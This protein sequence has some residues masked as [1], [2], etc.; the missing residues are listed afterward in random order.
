MNVMS[1][2]GTSLIYHYSLRTPFADECCRCQYEEW[3]QP[4]V[5][6]EKIRLLTIWEISYIRRMKE[7]AKK[8]AEATED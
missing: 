8:K 2:K 3:V 6:A 5:L 7:L 1:M 4:M